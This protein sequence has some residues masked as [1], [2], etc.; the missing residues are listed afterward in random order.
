[1][2][3]RIRAALLLLPAITACSSATTTLEPAT[4]TLNPE[5]AAAVTA[6]LQ[7]EYH[8]GQVYRRVLSDFGAVLPFANIVTA[9]QRHA[10]A[11]AGTLTTHGIAV[12][13]SA[14]TAANVPGFA[15]VP[16]ACAAAA[17][18]EVSNI[19]LYDTLLALD[20][21][22]DVR[23]VFTNNRRASLEGHLPA[24]TRCQ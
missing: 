3:L 21:P 24:F 19:A 7:D 12:P 5:V 6:A 10:T 23:I 8:A 22:D 4:S 17:T 14:W 18:A 16:D 1:M 13:A 9:E 15:S 2:S 11:L 20:L